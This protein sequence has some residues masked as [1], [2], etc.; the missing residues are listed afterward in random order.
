MEN[1]RRWVVGGVEE[2]IQLG[3]EVC[4]QAAGQMCESR[5]CGGG[6]TQVINK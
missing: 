1:R 4:S 5:C 2:A 6:R 3:F